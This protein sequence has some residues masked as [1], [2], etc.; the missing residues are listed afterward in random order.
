V[1]SLVPDN[2]RLRAFTKVT[3]QPGEQQTVTF[4][5]P[6][7]DLAF[8]GADGRWV[9]EVGDFRLRVAGLSADVS[10][11]ATHTYSDVSRKE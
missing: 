4:R 11:T 5:L 10:C 9:L 6:A 2:R 7:G 3:L 1:A 8:V